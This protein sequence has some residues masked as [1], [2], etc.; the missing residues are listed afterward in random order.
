[1]VTT[2]AASTHTERVK[3]DTDNNAHKSPV[4]KKVPDSAPPDTEINK[5]L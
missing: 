2:P 4:Q 5:L 3:K 1:M